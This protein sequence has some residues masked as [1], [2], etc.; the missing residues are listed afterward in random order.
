MTKR[1]AAALF[2]VSALLAA[3]GVVEAAGTP[4]ATFELKKCTDSIFASCPSVID[5]ETEKS[6][7]LDPKVDKYFTLKLSG[8]STTAAGKYAVASVFSVSKHA[9]LFLRVGRGASEGR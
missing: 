1:G 9:G 8:L 5:E 3:T 7:T 2:V 6:F 4:A